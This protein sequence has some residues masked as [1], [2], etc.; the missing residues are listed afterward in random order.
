MMTY[1][2]HSTSSVV[3]LSVPKIEFPHQ[4]RVQHTTIMSQHGLQLTLTNIVISGV[5]NTCVY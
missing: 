3:V 1:R 5:I 2:L 4:T